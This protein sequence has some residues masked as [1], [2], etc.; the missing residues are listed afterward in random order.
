MESLAP[1]KP[2]RKDFELTLNSDPAKDDSKAE[3]E[4]GTG[5]GGGL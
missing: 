3:S 5:K 4:P 1:P 2:S